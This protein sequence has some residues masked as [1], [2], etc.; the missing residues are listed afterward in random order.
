MKNDL[1]AVFKSHLTTEVKNII[2]AM[3]TVILGE[4]TSQLQ[5]LANIIF[6]TIQNNC[7]FQQP[8]ARDHVLTANGKT[9]KPSAKLLCQWI[10]TPLN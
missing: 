3:N 9:K 5:V 1:L 8:L 4:M 2:H 10:K 6:K 7:I